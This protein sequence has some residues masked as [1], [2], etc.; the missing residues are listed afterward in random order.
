MAI[1]E[2]RTGYTVP[3]IAALQKTNEET[4][5]DDLKKMINQG[6]IK[7]LKGPKISVKNDMKFIQENVLPAFLDL[8]QKWP[9]GYKLIM[10]NK[11]FMIAIMKYDSGV[12]NA[13]AAQVYTQSASDERP[14]A[15]VVI[16]PDKVIVCVNAFNEFDPSFV[17]D[18]I[19]HE[20]MHA[21]SNLAVKDGVKIEFLGNML[22]KK[23]N[24]KLTDIAKRYMERQATAEKEFGNWYRNNKKASD[25]EKYET[26]IS[27]MNR[28]KCWAQKKLGSYETLESYFKSCYLDPH[29]A[30]EVI[31]FGLMNYFG[32][33]EEKARLL[34]QEFGLYD[35][36]E[37]SAIPYVN[38]LASKKSK[39]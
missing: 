20:L 4:V 37:R 34:E 17:R 16:R 11:N 23:Y 10:S 25:K 28:N 27:I 7:T 19:Y 39:A 32:T 26:F 13:A 21:V 12:F 3:Q 33:P 30:E 6:R 36:I 5:M 2:I 8:Y 38:G 18:G 9:Q 14:A 31:A 1:P 29:N 15:S 35:L 24:G 22:D